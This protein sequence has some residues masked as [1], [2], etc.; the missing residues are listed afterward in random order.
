MKDMD[1]HDDRAIFEKEVVPKTLTQAKVAS[2]AQ[3]IAE[4]RTHLAASIKRLEEVTI[5]YQMSRNELERSVYEQR[6]DNMWTSIHRLVE[7]NET[8]KALERDFKKNCRKE[9]ENLTATISAL[10][11]EIKQLQEKITEI[12]R[13]KARAETR[14]FRARVTTAGI[15]REQASEARL[16]EE[17]PLARELVQY[18]RRFGELYEQMTLKSDEHRRHLATFN[19]LAAQVKYI[20]E[21]LSLLASVKEGF[22]AAKNNVSSAKEFASQL[23]PIVME[24]KKGVIRSKGKL[25]E[26]CSKLDE[27]GTELTMLSS[28]Q[29]SYYKAVRELQESFQEFEALSNKMRG[30]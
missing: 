17:S 9:L 4:Q 12:L 29:R 24:F 25:Q 22:R 28:K 2:F 5:T 14:L 19:Y 21:H 13:A 7:T 6:A 1:S 26:A 8:L 18:E 3:K 20:E 30:A 27:A 23:P 15:S 16:D 11:V 10:D